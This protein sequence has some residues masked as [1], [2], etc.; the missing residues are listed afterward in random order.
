MPFLSTLFTP[1]VSNGRWNEFYEPWVPGLK[2]LSPKEPQRFLGQIQ[3]PY[4]RHHNPLLI[5]NCSWILTIH[6]DKI[7]WKKSPWKQRNGLQKWAKIPYA[8]HHNSLLITNHSWILTVH[9]DRIFWEKPPWKQRKVIK[10]GALNIQA[11]GYIGAR[12]VYGIRNNF[13]MYAHS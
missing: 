7:F 11:A 6:K 5:T 8:R 1:G 9:K 4:M 13:S 10:N 12:T 3:I 2:T